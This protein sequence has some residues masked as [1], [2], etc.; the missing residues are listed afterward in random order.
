MKHH[1]PG[2]GPRL[3]ETCQ[4]K[5]QAAISKTAMRTRG[6]PPGQWCFMGYFSL[7]GCFLPPTNVP[8]SLSWPQTPRFFCAASA[9]DSFTPIHV[10]TIVLLP[11]CVTRWVTCVFSQ[12][13]PTSVTVNCTACVLELTVAFRLE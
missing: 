12:R 4:G 2:W 11:L 6:P 9:F 10:F 5:I 13:E 8:G 3:V 7:G 1:C